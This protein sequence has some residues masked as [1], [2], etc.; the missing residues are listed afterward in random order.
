MCIHA[1]QQRHS[2]DIVFYVTSFLM[3]GQD[4][5][6]VAQEKQELSDRFEVKDNTREV[7]L[8]LDIERG[9]AR[10]RGRDHHYHAEQLHQ[11]HPGEVR[12]AGLHSGQ[13][14]CIRAGPISGSRSTRRE[15]SWRNGNEVFPV[16]NELPVLPGPMCSV[17]HM[18]CCESTAQGLQLANRSSLEG[19]EARAPSPPI[20]YKRGCFMMEDLNKCIRIRS[21]P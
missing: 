21:Q 4:D 6:L 9:Q 5:D 7:S 11:Q 16:Y 2:V 18:L 12:H 19:G 1:W 17:R 10:R 20:V 14:R 8:I 15:S 3:I 13:H